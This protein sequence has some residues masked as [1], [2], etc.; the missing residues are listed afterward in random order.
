MATRLW[1]F[2]TTDPD[3]AALES[4]DRVADAADAVLGLAEALKEDNP[5]LGRVAALV[6][7][8][9]SLLAAINAPLGKLI[10]ATLPFV[11]ISTGLLRVYGETAKKE[12]TLAQA[13]ALMSQAA[14]LESL[15]E[16]VKQHPKI[17][18]WLIAKDSTP[19]ARTIT[20]PVK[21]LGIFELT[22]QEAR[23]ATLH[24]QQS[25]LA[26][27][28]NSALQARLV[29]LGT[30]PEQADRITQVVAKNTNRHM[31]TAIAAAGDSLKHQLEGD[32]L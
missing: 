1:N 6:S 23:L 5:N 8:L 20:L 28:F 32:R 12:P 11:S 16:F 14:Y 7:Q 3:L 22:D 13:V 4:V 27:A 9:D 2:L 17:E 31:K 29:Q 18:Q 21:A 10:G 19:Q 25:A 26:G 15:R 30:T 24:F